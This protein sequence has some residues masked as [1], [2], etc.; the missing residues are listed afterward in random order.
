M[1]YDIYIIVERIEIVKNEITKTMSSRLHFV[2]VRDEVHISLS[3]FIHKN[4]WTFGVKK[5]Y[6]MLKKKKPDFATY[7][8]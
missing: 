1:K 2:H 6:L 7:K 4:F 5:I 8:N 3:D